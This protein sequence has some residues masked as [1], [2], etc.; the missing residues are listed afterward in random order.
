MSIEY[1]KVDAVEPAGV[2]RDLADVVGSALGQGLPAGVS[3]LALCPGT[4]KDARCA[5]ALP[6]HRAQDTFVRFIASPDSRC[7]SVSLRLVLP[8]GQSGR[9]HAPHEMAD[10]QKEPLLGVGLPKAAIA[11]AT[12]ELEAPAGYARLRAADHG[13]NAA[14][15]ASALSHEALAILAKRIE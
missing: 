4:G 7:W 14:K 10:S 2:L 15:L 6:V 5:V 12:S 8:A 9:W 11:I 3:H 13:L 1:T